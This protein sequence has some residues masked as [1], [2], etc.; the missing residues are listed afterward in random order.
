MRSPTLAGPMALAYVPESVTRATGRSSAWLRDGDRSTLVWLIPFCLAG[1]YVVVFLAQL[2]HNLWVIGWNSDYSSDFTIPT[3]VVNAGTGGNTVLGTA[4]GYLPL[5]LGLLT[6]KLPLHRELWELAPTGVFIATAVTVG[7]SVAQVAD[8]RA[9]TLATLLIL[10]ASP[11][12]LYIFIAPIPHSMIAYPGTALL[13][14]YLLWLARGD[15]RRRWAAFALPPLAGVLLGVCIASDFLLVATGVIPFALTAALAGL[16]RARRPRLVAVSVLTS[17]AVAVP[18]AM[19]TSTTMGSLGFATLPPSSETAAL[20]TL[21]RHAELIWEGLR[22]LLNAYLKDTTPSVL[23]NGL[24]VACEIIMVTGL[25]TLLLV[26]VCAT[27][28]FTWSGLRRR[29]RSTSPELARSLHIIYWSGSAV[30]T[31]VSFGLSTRTEYVHEAYYATLVLSLAAVVVLLTRSRSPA[32]W[33]ICAGASIFF[34]ASI[35]GLTSDYMESYTL[36]IARTPGSTTRTY[37]SPVAR[38]ADQIVAFTRANDAAIGYAGY[39]DA[40]DFTWTSRER[41][42]VR[43]V[44]ICG[45]PEGAGICPFFIATVPAWYIPAQRRTFLLVDS[46]EGYLPVLPG[47][48]GEPIAA[49]T[50]GAARVYVYPYDLA[51]RLEP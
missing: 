12:A 22:G 48:L 14:A 8:R 26:G 24:G 9:G 37:V 42:A 4:G 20:S 2:P 3:S 32:R 31:C 30:C 25:T 21:P 27:A 45:T 6:A 11:R 18:I 17:T 38:Y 50:F 10:A 49:R 5:W 23:N 33:L 29:E 15:G 13:G 1:A 34:A 28:R 36:P 7:W 46:T 41:V 47:G 35:V 51:S 16:Q 19:L 43:P 40:S 39:G 44:R